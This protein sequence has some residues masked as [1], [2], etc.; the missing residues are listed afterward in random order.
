MIRTKALSPV[1]ARAAAQRGRRAQA[2]LSVR[3][4][5][6]STLFFWLRRIGIGDDG[7]ASRCFRMI[8][9]FLPESISEPVTDSALPEL[10]LGAVES[11]SYG[12]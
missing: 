8:V 6:S 1:R 10:V 7:R 2:G 12:I 5:S 9:E 4:S 11:S 3:A